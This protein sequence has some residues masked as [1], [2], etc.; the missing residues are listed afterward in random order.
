[1]P[2]SM[3]LIAVTSSIQLVM[4]L[5]MVLLLVR[6]GTVDGSNTS[7]SACCVKHIPRL[8][9]GI[10]HLVLQ[11]RGKGAFVFLHL[12]KLMLIAIKS[13]FHAVTLF[14][15]Q[16]LIALLQLLR[17]QSVFGHVAG[18][19]RKFVLQRVSMLTADFVVHFN[20]RL[21]AG[22]GSAPPPEAEAAGIEESFGAGAADG[23]TV[24]G[25][26]YS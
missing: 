16:L 18:V 20:I 7:S 9:D 6:I 14:P 22:R 3:H 1:M 12:F 25:R 23:V 13:L 21:H 4:L 8:V 26:C 24:V 15:P 19:S 5:L 2:I 10:T 17:T 11:P